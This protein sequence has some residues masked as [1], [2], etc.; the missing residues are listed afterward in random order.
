M[1]AIK[2]TA[3]GLILTIAS[4]SFAPAQSLRESTGPAEF[5]PSSFKGS[6]YVDSSG[7]VFVRAGVGDSITWVPRVSRDRRVICG[8]KP[9]FAKAQ[10]NAVPVIKDP[11]AQTATAPVK[12]AP[13]ATVTAPA[14]AKPVAPVAAPTTKTTQ[15]APRKAS[16]ECPDAS[17]V[18]KQYIGNSGGYDVRCGPQQKHPGAYGVGPKVA[19]QSPV[20]PQSRVIRP[21]TPQIPK[22]YKPAFDDDRMNPYRNRRTAMGDAQMRLVWTDTVPRRLVEVEAGQDLYLTKA[23]IEY[24]KA[25]ASKRAKAVKSPTAKSKSSLAKYRYVNIGAFTDPKQAEATARKLQRS[26]LPVRYGKY[27]KGGKTLKMVLVGPFKTPAQLQNAMS[28]AQK[29]G[30]RNASYQK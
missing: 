20:S 8:A 29:A 23:Q 5:P 19:P 9:T 6:Q 12:T 22:G 3:L 17:A 26:G 16:P 14:T 2:T 30:Y 7:C 28:K 13:A 4:A 24:R 1:R 27:K 11:P 18:S 21:A 15:T 10:P 25:N